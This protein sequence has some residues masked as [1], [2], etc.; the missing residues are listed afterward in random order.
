[1]ALTHLLDTS[2]YSQP[3]RNTPLERVMQR[4]SALGEDAVCI[5]A[6]VHAELLQG[7]VARNSKSFWS[8]Y[9]EMLAGQ[10]AVLPFDRGVA[11]TYA[12]LV[13]ELQQAGT[14]KPIADLMI[15]AT[16]KHHNLTIATLNLKDFTGIP[17]VNVECWSD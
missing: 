8:R 13:V 16:A 12:R 4:W 11:E 6:L 5:A 3:V 17:G 9:E 14:P 10:Y 1:M 2:V 15:A 7:L